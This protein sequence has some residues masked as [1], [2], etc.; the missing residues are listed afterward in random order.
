MSNEVDTFKI[1]TPRVTIETVKAETGFDLIDPKEFITT[2]PPTPD[3]LEI[4]RI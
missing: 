4:L 3:E 1:S 2:A